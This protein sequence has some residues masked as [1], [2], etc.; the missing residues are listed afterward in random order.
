[1]MICVGKLS[2]FIHFLVLL[3]GKPWWALS[4]LMAANMPTIFSGTKSIR[5]KY[6]KLNHMRIYVYTYAYTHIYIYIYRYTHV[7]FIYIDRYIY[8]YICKSIIKIIFLLCPSHHSAGSRAVS[9][10]ALPP[11]ACRKPGIRQGMIDL[12]YERPWWCGKP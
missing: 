1:M 5:I 12:E 4:H 11:G 6:P 3:L 7:T 8:I 9:A 2:M 10:G